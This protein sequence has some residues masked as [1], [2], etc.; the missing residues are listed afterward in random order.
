MHIHYHIHLDKNNTKAIKKSCIT[1]YYRISTFITIDQE[2]MSTENLRSSSLDNQVHDAFQRLKRYRH[3]HPN[4]VF[5]WS[6]KLQCDVMRLQ[7]TI[8]G[9]DRA[10]NLFD[11]MDDLDVKTIAL[12]HVMFSH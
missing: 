7:Q 4:L 11:S 10:I 5:N 2:N 3:T 1:H 9:L 6:K 12:I 8:D